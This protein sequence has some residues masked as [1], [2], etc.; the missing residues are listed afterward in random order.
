MGLTKG[1]LPRQITIGGYTFDWDPIGNP[2]DIPLV[3]QA[4]DGTTNTH[5]TARK[6]NGT[7]GYQVPA[8][9]TLYV[10]A[11]RV[12]TTAAATAAQWALGYGDTDVGASSAAAPTNPIA[13]NGG[14]AQ[15]ITAATL[16]SSGEKGGVNFSIPASKYLDALSVGSA[17]DR[18]H[19]ELYCKL[20]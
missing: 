7:A 18:S 5:H 11:A 12:V 19:I 20:V 10:V 6:H 8:S 17:A 4:T 16:A 1:N 2:N 13:D 3:A 15:L 14:L 9:R